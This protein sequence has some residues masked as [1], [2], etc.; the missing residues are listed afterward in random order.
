MA[1]VGGRFCI[2]RWEASLVEIAP[3]GERPFSPYATPEGRRRCAPSRVEGVVPQGYIS[4][5]QASR[6]C[7]ASGKRLCLEDE[8]VTACR[9][10]P[11]RAFPYGD[12]RR[13]GRL[14]RLGRLSAARLLP[15]R[16]ADVLAGPMNDPRLNQHRTRW[17]GRAR[18]RMLERLRRVRHGRQPPRV[19]HVAAGRRSAGATTTTR[20]STATAAPTARPP[21]P[22][23]TTTTRPASAAAPARRSELRERAARASVAKELGPVDAAIAPA[24]LALLAE[25]VTVADELLLVVE[26]AGDPPGLGA[27]IALLRDAVVAIDLVG[28]GAALALLEEAGLRSPAGRGRRRAPCRRTRASSCRRPS[29]RTSRRA[30]RGR[31]AHRGTCRSGRCGR[32][33]PGTPAGRGI[34]ARDRSVRPCRRAPWCRSVAQA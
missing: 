25:L 13:E 9:G 26:R 2:D 15:R 31:R 5:D 20:T 34:V 19:G 21:T 24:A 17:P 30:R 10:D 23:S 22:R 33:R 3:D 32:R 7:A 8:W 11:P 18:S 27:R 16:A 4:R 12:A 29:R 28:L 14:Q 1:L 6:A